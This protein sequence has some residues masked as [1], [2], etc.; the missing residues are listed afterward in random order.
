M[1]GTSKWVRM[2]VSYL[3]VVAAVALLGID[4]IL[5]DKSMM[6]V[7]ESVMIV[8]RHTGYNTGMMMYG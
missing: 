8:M 5:H 4:C 3:S 2:S 7:A 6:V 1:S